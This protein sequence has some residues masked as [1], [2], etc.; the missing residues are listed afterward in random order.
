MTQK[1]LFLKNCLI[2]GE[3]DKRYN[4]FMHISL[5]NMSYISNIQGDLGDL[6]FAPTTAF[7]LPQIHFTP[8]V[9]QLGGQVG[10]LKKRNSSRNSIF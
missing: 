1:T 6:S 4:E 9:S 2:I 5:R 10:C 8:L 3:M 7:F